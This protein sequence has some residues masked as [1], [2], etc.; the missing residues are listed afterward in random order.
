MEQKGEAAIWIEREF[1]G[2][3]GPSFCSHGLEHER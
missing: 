3:L 2:N 1:V